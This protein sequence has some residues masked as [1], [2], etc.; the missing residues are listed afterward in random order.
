VHVTRMRSD[1]ARAALT[2]DL[3]LQAS[4]DQSDLSNQR[5]PTSTTGT[6]TCPSYGSCN[7]PNNPPVSA[8]GGGCDV[9]KE[10]PAGNELLLGLA[11]AVGLIGWGFARRRRRA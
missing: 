8:Y 1:V 10:P 11:G 4:A 9:A 2:A 6:Y 7:N 3:Q 5:Y